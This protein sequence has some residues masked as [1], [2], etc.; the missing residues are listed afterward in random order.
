ML[1]GGPRVIA[2]AAVDSSGAPR[3]CCELRYALSA[4]TVRMPSLAERRGELVEI[5]RSMLPVLAARMGVDT[6]TLDDDAAEVIALTV[7]SIS[8]A[9]RCRRASSRT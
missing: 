7:I 5:A 9:R 1:V 8:N 4:L 6:P 3:L 2:L